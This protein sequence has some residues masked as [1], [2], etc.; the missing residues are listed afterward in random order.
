M[1]ELAKKLIAENKRTKAKSLDLGRCGLRDFPKELFELEWLEKLVMCDEY[2]DYDKNIWVNSSNHGKTNGLWKIDE[3]IQKLFNLEQL[4]IGGSSY[5]DRWLITDITILGTLSNLKVLYLSS[6]AIQ[7]ISHLQYIKN[8]TTLN[9]RS[10]KIHD[11]SCFK[12]FPSLRKLDLRSNKLLDINGLRYLTELEFLDLHYNGIKNINEISYLK[13]I[14]FLCLSENKINDISSLKELLHLQHLFLNDNNISNIA[15][16]GKLTNLI[17]VDISD[18]LCTDIDVVRNLY[19]LKHLKLNNNKKVKNYDVLK[20]LPSLEDLS[21]SKN[22]I[23]DFSV[24]NNLQNLKKIN[25]SHNKI[26]DF[27]ITKSLLGLN[28]LNLSNNNIEN[29]DEIKKILNLNYLDLS[30]NKINDIN[31]LQNLKYIKSLYVTNNQISDI[32]GI[33][34][35]IRG[36]VPVKWNWFTENS[37]CVKNNPFV[38]PP[39]EIVKQGNEAILRYFEEKERSG[40][41]Y[42]YEA[43]VL[44][45]GEGNVGKTTL[46][47]KL[48][49]AEADMPPAYARTPGIEIHRIPFQHL[50]ERN[51]FLNVWDFGG[52]DIYHNTHHFFLTKRSLYVLVTNTRSQED[53]FDYWIPNI[54]LFGG[55]SPILIVKNKWQD[56]VKG[57][58]IDRKISITRFRQNEAFNIPE[59]L[60]EV[61][62]YTKENLDSLSQTIL[63]HATQLPL[64]G[65][66]VPKSWV[67]VRN[68]LKE[69]SA[70]EAYISFSDF[71][72]SCREV[73]I[74]E[75]E[76]ISD[77]ARFFHDLGIVLWYEDIA[78]LKGKVILQP[79]WATDAVYLIIN[80]EQIQNQKGHFS[81]QDLERIWT[82][83][84][85]RDMCH[86]LLEMMK[87]FRLCYQKRS[88]KKAFI[89]PS[90]LSPEPPTLKWNN[91]DNIQLQYEY[92]F[93][94]KGIVNQLS[95]ELH[96][97]IQS[98]RHIW[99]QG[100]VLTDKNGLF[101][102]KIEEDWFNR[103]IDIRTSGVDARAILRRITDTIEGDIHQYFP[104]V[105]Y[106]KLVPCICST[107]QT[108]EQ[109]EFYA[110]DVLLKVRQRSSAFFCNMGGDSFDIQKALFN[111][112]ERG[113]DASD[114]DSP[115]EEK[116]RRKNNDSKQ[117]KK[118]KKLFI[119]YSEE[120]KTYLEGLKQ[121]LAILDRKGELVTW[122]DTCIFAGEDWSE[123]TEAALKEADMILLLVSADFLANERIDAIEVATALRLKEIGKTAIVP[124]VIRPCMWKRS[125]FAKYSVLPPKGKPISKWADRDEAWLSVVEGIAELL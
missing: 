88:R 20:E 63:H 17:T 5:H 34:H 56:A 96:A 100:V 26:K 60:L 36:G 109:P 58:S 112:G 106:K 80:N 114:S 67:E 45:V 18:N 8:L 66:E 93:M 2:W 9:L 31:C 110:Y 50:D 53:N 43:K 23:S 87:E 105:D 47:T 81:Y 1:S 120:D 30:H 86:E 59:N 52:Q 44:L 32:K 28:W 92:S 75:A 51:F 82:D 21:I 124:I 62:L 72:D 12:N 41:D 69:R 48:E 27:L 119:A 113:H 16:L 116:R 83:V 121:Q 95:A 46:R 94:P 84:R 61:N 102:A 108:S 13:K 115:F 55:K 4:Y 122:D 78:A 54:R 77:L 107:C 71:A 97:Y 64:V 11:I 117:S 10:N 7:D 22:S 111:I 103:K 40:K 3:R 33:L 85:H 65:S 118:A 70:T 90:L 68:T 123:R 89:I 91:K 42:L 25:I 98:D 38:I 35:L 6:N 37:I 101:K 79:E 19:Q 125:D 15:P 29:I 39:I 14:L 76:K 104:G 57:S 24:V 99:G 73:G 49:D 74:E